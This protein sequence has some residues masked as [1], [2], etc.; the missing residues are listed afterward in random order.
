MK[1]D[2]TLLGDKELERLLGRLEGNVPG[3]VVRKA[4]RD[5]GKAVFVPA[6]KARIPV[7]TGTLKAAKLSVRS[8]VYKKYGFIAAY[9]GFPTRENLDKA[10]KALYATKLKKPREIINAKAYYPAAVE[11]GHPRAPAHPFL[12]PAFDSNESKAFSRVRAEIAKG[13]QREWDK[14]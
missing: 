8:R 14:K 3:K 12:R 10:H 9:V 6:I 13:V 5:T 1:V 2:I 4:L 11:Y 7:W